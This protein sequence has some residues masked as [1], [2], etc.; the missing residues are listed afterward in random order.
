VRTPTTGRGTVAI[1][2][3]GNA[4]GAPPWAACDRLTQQ[5]QRRRPQSITVQ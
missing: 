1:I 3:I 4:E 5:L 2:L